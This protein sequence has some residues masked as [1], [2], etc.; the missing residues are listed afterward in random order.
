[1]AQTSQSLTGSKSLTLIPPHL[2]IAKISWSLLATVLLSTNI[3]QAQIQNQSSNRIPVA[4][5]TLGTQVT[6]ANNNF[7]ITGGLTR[8]QSVLHS[9]QD[10]SVPTGGTATFSS[11]VGTQAIV[12]RVTGNLSSD[13]NGIIN[14]QGANFFLINPNGIVFGSGAQLNVGKAFVASTATSAN[15][16]DSVGT[17][18]PFGTRNI[19]DAPLLSINPSVALNVALLNFD[20]NN[21]PITN[22]G[23]LQTNN[24]DQYIAL[25]GGNIT[26]DTVAG[27][28]N[29]VA[30]GGRVDL[31]GLST[32]GTVGI[33]QSFVYG[34]SGFVRSD[35]TLIDGALVNVTTNQAVGNVNTFFFDNV[36]S[37]GSTINADAEN[38]NIF[39]RPNGSAPPVRF[40]E[41]IIPINT[42]SGEQSNTQLS[43]DSST[44][45]KTV[46]NGNTSVRSRRLPLLTY[47]RTR[48]V[49]ACESG[50]S[51]LAITGRGGFPSDA[52]DP[53]NSDVVW[54]DPRIV[55]DQPLVDSNVLPT[56]KFPLPAIGLGANQ[57]G[58]MMILAANSERVPIRENISCPP[59]SRP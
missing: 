46:A 27:R 18:Y 26:L 58:Q 51:K 59:I 53:L 7:T 5:S 31:G 45:S 52:N 16:V 55:K 14:T 35:L 57:Q 44:T 42:Q 15:L 10:F 28:G 2:M 32:A 25:I 29:I 54:R 12:T 13:I 36:T 21:G 19:N 33:N 20:G 9:F 23:T 4:D 43:E 39:N 3:A 1:M 11:A 17:T 8:G 37:R 48:I 22:Y 56:S 41:P 47:D 6:G 24:S 40:L 49:Q 38:V 50:E 34:G 30:P